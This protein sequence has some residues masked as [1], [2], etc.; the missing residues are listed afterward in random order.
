MHTL[1]NQ[2]SR[3][4]F[5]LVEIMIVVII[6]GLLAAM[7]IPAYHNSQKNAKSATFINDVRTYSAA[8]EVFSLETGDFPEDVG[9]GI[10]PMGLGE[11]IPTMK[12]TAET[13]IGG[14]WDFVKND[15]GIV[16]G[17]GASGHTASNAQLMHIE[18]KWD[19]GNLS[20]G[21]LRSLDGGYYYVLAE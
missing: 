16:S 7:A 20:T 9:P 21:K 11:Y 2:E 5:T 1:N 15:K 19:D 4:G 18:Q 3:R 12:W 13:P 8:A 17:F 14:R 6:I 10:M